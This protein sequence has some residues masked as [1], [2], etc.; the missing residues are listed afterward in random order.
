MTNYDLI[1]SKEYKYLVYLVDELR[2]IEIAFKELVADRDFKL[3]FL[4]KED[5]GAAYESAIEYLDKIK[6]QINN[7][8]LNELAS[9]ELEVIGVM[10]DKLVEYYKYFR[11][12]YE[13]IKV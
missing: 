11:E 4:L 13:N 9:T 5:L 1:L 2:K 10:I 7:L 3:T 6:S 12:T 8:V